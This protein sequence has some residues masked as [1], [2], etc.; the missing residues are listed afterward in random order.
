VYAFLS[1]VFFS[2]GFE[3]M[4]S[5]FWAYDSGFFSSTIIP[6]SLARNSFAYAIGDDTIVLPQPIA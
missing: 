5:I 1:I 4:L 3:R 6:L 2:S